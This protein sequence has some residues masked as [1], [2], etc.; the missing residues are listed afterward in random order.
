MQVKLNSDDEDLNMA[1]D[2]IVAIPIERFD[3]DLVTP[4][5]KCIKR[6][7][8]CIPFTFPDAPDQST[9]VKFVTAD[10]D[11]ADNLP[12]GI[13]DPNEK[14][15]YV[16]GDTPIVDITGTVNVSSH[17]ASICLNYQR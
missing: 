9:V 4:K 15:L 2:S 7:G 16:S 17:F 6:K 11:A 10:E 5:P 13:A 14:L 3:L 1:I 12:D 8:V